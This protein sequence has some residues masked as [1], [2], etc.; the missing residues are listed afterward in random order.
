MQY[1]TMNLKEAFPF[2]YCEPAEGGRG[3]LKSS[4]I[5]SLPKGGV[6]ISTPVIAGMGIG[7]RNGKGIKSRNS[8]CE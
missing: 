6:A 1:Q 3:N 4:V 5:A 7:F 2:C 8:D